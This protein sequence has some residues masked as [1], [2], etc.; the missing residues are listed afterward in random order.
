MTDLLMDASTERK[1]RVRANNALYKLCRE[2]HAG[3]PLGSL[4]S[5]LIQNG[6][7]GLEEAIYC[8]RDGNVHEQVG[9]RT[10]LTMTYHKMEYS[11]RYEIVVYLN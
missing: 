6:F 1:A 3:L 4:D 11:G 5:V 2:Y 10:W 7:T 8:G 9:R